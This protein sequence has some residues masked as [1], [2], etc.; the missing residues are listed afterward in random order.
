MSKS[1]E[2]QRSYLEPPT[3]PDFRSTAFRVPHTIRAEQSNA[4][5]SNLCPPQVK[6]GYEYAISV[7]DGGADTLAPHAVTATA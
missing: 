7:G 3:F 4:S 6:A 2:K 5:T 1:I